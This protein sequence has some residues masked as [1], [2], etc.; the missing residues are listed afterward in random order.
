MFLYTLRRINLLLITLLAL[1]FVAYLLDYRLIGHQIS[2][3][4]GYPDFLRRIFAGDLGLSSVSGLPVLDEIHH[5]FPATLILCLAAFAISLLVGIPLG[6]L[7]AL[8]QGKTLDLSIM[9]A[10][11][12]GYAVPVFWLALLVVMLFSLDLGWL[13]ASGQISLLYDVP[14]I[15]GIAVIDVLLSHEPWRQAALHDALRHLILPSLVL[16]VVPTT[17][18]IRHVR[19]SLID[20]MKQNYIKAAASRGLSKAQIVWRHGLKN[21]LPPVLPL[22]GLQLGSV[23]TSAMITEV[24]F[25]WHGIGRWLISSIALQDY[26]AIRGATLVVASFVILTS[27]STELLTTLIYPARRKELYAK[28]D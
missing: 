25:E 6:T 4:S 14:P 9:T 23:L 15:T 3:W 11:L 13:P 2:F 10:G 28:Q 26:A 7:A 18:V 12:I 8:S 17:E 21:A 20:V 5:Y 19:S 1:T 22:L 24:V 16:A 27:V